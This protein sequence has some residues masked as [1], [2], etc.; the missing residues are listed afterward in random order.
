MTDPG[1]SP[2]A[3]RVRGRILATIFGVTA[4][5]LLVF[6]TQILVRLDREVS[7]LRDELATKQDL[8]NLAVNI[9]PA[10]PA[11]ATLENTCTDCHTKE[12]FQEAHGITNDVRDLVQ[13]MSTL[14]GAHI[15]KDE[16]PQAEAALT[17]MKCAHCH[18]I[19]RLKQLAI[20]GPEQRWQ[21]IVRMMKEPGAAITQE[22]AQRIRDFYGDFWGWHTR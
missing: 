22:D 9:G 14:S 2:V 4:L 16:V 7:H 10:D 19:D 21:L 8:S 13:R 3:G 18:S 12:R 15:S 5:L 11:M 20:L 1:P 6:V 17:Y